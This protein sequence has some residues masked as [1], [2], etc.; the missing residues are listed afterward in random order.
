MTP[1]EHLLLLSEPY[2]DPS[3]LPHDEVRD[4]VNIELPKLI[5]HNTVTR[6]EAAMTSN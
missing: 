2:D 5:R 4:F 3:Q 6:N 1:R